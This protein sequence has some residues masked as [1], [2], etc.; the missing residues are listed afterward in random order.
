MI[1]WVLEFTSRNETK[2]TVKYKSGRRYEYRESDTMPMTVVNFLTADTTESKTVY[3]PDE[4]FVNR[5]TTYR[6][7]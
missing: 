6:S 2:W 3:I 5:R 4:G 1:E 7:K